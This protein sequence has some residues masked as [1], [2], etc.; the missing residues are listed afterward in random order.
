MTRRRR[1][2]LLLA[3]WIALAL[4]ISILPLLTPPLR[5]ADAAASAGADPLEVLHRA[6]SAEVFD[7]WLAAY[8]RKDAATTNAVGLGGRRDPA[9]TSIGDL[10]WAMLVDCALIVP[11]Y[12]GLFIL[13]ARQV[14]KRGEDADADAQPMEDLEA[15]RDDPTP[16][17][18]SAMSR[19]ERPLEAR[20]DRRGTAPLNRRLH[21][22]I[23]PPVFAALADLVE[24]GATLRVAEDSIVGLLANATVGDLHILTALKWGGFALASMALGLQA[25]FG[26]YRA[27]RPAAERLSLDLAAAACVVAGVL[28]AGSL[29]G[30]PMWWRTLGLVAW[31]VAG[32]FFCHGELTA[33]FQR[34]FTSRV[35]TEA[36]HAAADR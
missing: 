7:S 30:Y 21:F 5:G 12:L 22:L 19:V 26:E 2:R 36:Q 17:V 10:R 27:A 28:L 18:G 34:L 24:N 1:V 3:A 16:S 29:I 11:G 31:A 9:G 6:S 35:R 33:L 32:G 13:F 15:P 14:C 23:A 25:V 8:W 4:G 20:L